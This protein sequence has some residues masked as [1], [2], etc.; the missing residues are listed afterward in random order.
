MNIKR[1][2]LLGIHVTD[3]MKKA[4]EVQKIFSD[5]G[6]YIKTRLGLHDAT[7]EYCAS[8]GVVVL[9]ILDN[10]AVRQEMVSRLQQIDGLEVKEMVF[11][12]P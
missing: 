7:E 9:E 12:H 8:S 11:D 4:V 3:R 10:E 6:C 1:H 5:Y 2:I